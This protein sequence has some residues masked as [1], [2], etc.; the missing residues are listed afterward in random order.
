MGTC[1]NMKAYKG[2]EL[3]FERVVNSL[4]MKNVVIN[5]RTKTVDIQ[6]ASN[7]GNGSWGMID[8]LINHNNYILVN[9]NYRLVKGAE[10]IK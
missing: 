9:N 4:S 5:A 6:A 10:I 3:S 7:L 2:R 8:F 1:E